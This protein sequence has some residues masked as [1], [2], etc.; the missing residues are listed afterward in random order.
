MGEPAR[1][2][3]DL[4]VVGGGIHG[5]AIAR[6]AAG[7]GLSVLLIERGDLGGETSS[8]SSKLI[9]GGLRYLEHLEFR[10]VR[11]ALREREILLATAPHLVEPMRFVLPHTPSLRPAWMI[12]LGL[13][14][15]DHLARRGSLEGSGAADLAAGAYGAAL[16]ARWRKGY[17]YSDCRTDDARLVLA[18]AL[19]AGDRG[20][21]VATRTALVTA[22]RED[23]RWRLTLQPQ[24]RATNAHAGERRAV[25]ASS[26]VNAAGPWAVDMLSEVRGRPTRRRLRL[27]KGSHIVV[28][29]LYEGGHAYILQQDDRRIVFVI[30]YE[31]DFTMIGTTEVL[32]QRPGPVSAS[33]EEV[34]YLCAASNAFLEPQVSP[35][36]VVWSFAGTRALC[37]DGRADASAVTRDYVL[38]LDSE[39]G[40]APLLSVFGGK[41]TTARRLAERAV[42][43]LSPFHEDIGGRW[44]SEAM[45]PGG[46]LPGA[47]GRDRIASFAAHL[48]TTHPRL[49]G[50]LLSGLARRHGSE[51]ANLL[52]D[53]QDAAAL[54]RDFGGGL[55][56]RELEWMVTRQWARGAGDV[57][58][59]RS[60]LGLVLDETQ[61]GAVAGWLEARLAR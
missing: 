50:G 40:R 30:P 51:A 2:S 34:A 44:T 59:R 43:K 60:K 61:L 7:R 35:A 45:L 13:F 36:D 26:L 46:E 29:R 9:H 28:P 16:Q 3:Y 38:E 25:S 54:G 53:V 12:R 14:L 37:D 22:R 1:D 18:N 10:L 33:D 56:E 31:R 5:T 6:D 47:V 52:G 21:E 41:L 23:G 17:V 11:E 15:Y 49:D 48:A 20:A 42:D 32:L 19:A 8:A 58:W 55:T 24:G 57:L 27:V 39:K 4:A